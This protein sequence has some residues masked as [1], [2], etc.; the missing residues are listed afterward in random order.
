MF[1]EECYPLPFMPSS[2]S[3]DLRRQ[4]GATQ[5][6]MV[7]VGGSIGTGLL[8]GAGEA[9]RIAGPAVILAYLIAAAIMWVVAMAM[10]ELAS[11]HPGAGSFGVYA[12]IYLNPWAG[13]IARYGYWLA[14]VISIGAEMAAAATYMH[15]WIPGIP[16]ALWVIVFGAVLVG[17]NLWQVGHYANFEA[18]FSLAK[19]ATLVLFIVVGGALLA[20]GRVPAQFVV[21]DGFFPNGAVAPLL[22]VAFAIFTFGGVEMVAISSGEA[23]SAKEVSGAT[24]RMF[25]M[26]LF[27]YLGAIVVLVGMMPWRQAGVAQSPFV[28]VL[29]FIGV[30]RASDV[31]NFVVLTAALSGANGSLYVAS[32][33][34]FSLA[35]GGYAP[36]ALGRLTHAGS[37]RAA[38]MASSGGIAVAVVLQYF[39]PQ[40]AFLW[41]LGSALF[42]GFAAWLVALAAHISSR[43]RISAQDLANL[44]IRVPGGAVS[45]AVA[46]AGMIAAWAFSWWTSLRIGVYAA[47]VVIGVL[48]LAYWVNRRGRQAIVAA[49]D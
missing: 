38:L 21:Q 23:R 27:L 18:W 49:A 1:E 40:K 4:L 13:F 37:P 46:F 32:R 15:Y 25:A 16:G 12:E 17:I 31:M 34:L 9:I 44:S 6:A 36:A 5:M 48:S 11:R 39:A 45:S 29:T 24:R 33:T 42:G 41:M 22:A 47:P 26:L 30:P 14:M 43:R 35:R 2:D 28:T 8:L 20:G 3:Q 19:I 7:A 10:G